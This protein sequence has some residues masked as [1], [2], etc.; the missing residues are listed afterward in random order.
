MINV[1]LDTNAIRK[2]KILE[3]FYIDAIIKKILLKNNCLPMHIDFK[4]KYPTY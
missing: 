3:D 2:Y 1:Y 4:I